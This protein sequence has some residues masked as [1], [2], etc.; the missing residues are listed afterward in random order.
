MRHKRY[1]RAANGM[2]EFLR[3]YPEDGLIDHTARAQARR[4][5]R[6]GGSGRGAGPAGDIL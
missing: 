3:G 2:T 1:R 4:P 6:G 5:A